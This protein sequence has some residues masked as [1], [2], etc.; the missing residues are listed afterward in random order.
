M[1]RFLNFIRDNSGVT[2]IE[3]ALVA[4][5]I[6]VAVA[7]SIGLLGEAVKNLFSRVVDNWPAG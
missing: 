4:S 6:A 2:S 7:A 1:A 3:Y 5:L